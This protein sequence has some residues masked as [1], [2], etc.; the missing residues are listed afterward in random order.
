MG[1]LRQFATQKKY[2][3][4]ME[5]HEQRYRE[6][7][8]KHKEEEAL[9]MTLLEQERRQSRANATKPSSDIDS[10]RVM[11]PKD[12]GRAMSDIS[13]LYDMDDQQQSGRR[14]G[15]GQ[16]K[17][18]KPISIGQNMHFLKDK[19]DHSD[20]RPVDF[21]H[22]KV[23]TFKSLGSSHPEI[24]ANWR[25]KRAADFV[26]KKKNALDVP[27]HKGMPA[28]LTFKPAGP[29]HIPQ[30]PKDL[31]NKKVAP[32]PL[33]KGHA[34]DT[35][36]LTLGIG[37]TA[38]ADSTS[39]YGNTYSSSS[40]DIGSLKAGLGTLVEQLQKTEEEIARQELKIGLKKKNQSYAAAK[41]AKTTI[42]SDVGP[43]VRRGGVGG[44]RGLHSARSKGSSSKN[45]FL[46]T[47]P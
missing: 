17:K 30:K 22:Q 21:Y 47:S 16:T 12:S 39:G 45:S 2:F 33:P 8:R 7:I 10:V 46:M 42:V 40:A 38:P 6:S 29:V 9:Q 31:P 27:E 19:D 1:L 14:G 3:E 32:P 26:N 24:L 34:A 11:R 20:A 25:A 35:Y 23:S 44:G 36:H 18:S 5:E 13:D 41:G 43:S 37:S 15:A 28:N 4:R